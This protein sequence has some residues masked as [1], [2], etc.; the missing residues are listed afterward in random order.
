MS[1]YS[2]RQPVTQHYDC[3]LRWVYKCI[4]IYSI[5]STIQPEITIFVVDNKHTAFIALLRIL[6][7]HINAHIKYLFCVTHMCG[8]YL[9]L[10]VNNVKSL[11]KISLFYYMVSAVILLVYIHY[12]VF[13]LYSR[14]VWVHRTSITVWAFVH[15]APIYTT[16]CGISFLLMGRQLEWHPRYSI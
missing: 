10:I 11:H 4:H 6:C 7:M 13:K 3:T 12:I 15:C 5:R 2:A 8:W 14:S 16:I 9:N 1:S